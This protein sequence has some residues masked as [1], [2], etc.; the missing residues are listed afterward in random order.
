[1]DTFDEDIAIYRRYVYDTFVV[2]AENSIN[3]FHNHLNSINHNIQFI[4]ENETN[5]QLSFLDLLFSSS[6]NGTI[7]TSASIYKKDTHTGQYLNCNF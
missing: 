7:S 5:N 4:L 1:M 6:V 2:L 3:S